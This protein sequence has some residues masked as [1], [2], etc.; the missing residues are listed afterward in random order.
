MKKVA[1]SQSNY[2]PWK[3]YFDLIA[4]VD[5]FVL[6]DDMQFTRRDW[7][8]RNLIKTP[9]GVSWLTVPVSVK[10]KYTQK[11]FETEIIG[12]DWSEKHWKTLVQNY[13]QSPYFIEIAS[14]LEPIYLEEKF[15]HISALNQRL[16]RAICA[17]LNITTKITLS[18]WYN[19]GAGGRTERLAE[20]CRLTAA[21]HY[22]S[23]PAAKE[24]LD[25]V[26]FERQGTQVIWFDYQGYKEYPQLWGA[27]SQNVSILDLL[28]NCGNRSRDFMR[29]V[30]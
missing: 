24:Y 1:I 14:W 23:G 2:I 9:S 30:F 21:T 20:I 3:G 4:A 25:S 27:F 19:F 29:Y 17:Y 6:Y 16:I 28:F 5:E 18:S 26:V 10:G 13:K 22:V 15:T 8:N 11:I 12:S 7:R